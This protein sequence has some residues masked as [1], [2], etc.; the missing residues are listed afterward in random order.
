MKTCHFTQTLF[1]LWAKQS[2]LLLLNAA[3]LAEKHEIPILMYD[4]GRERTHNLPHSRRANNHYTS[5]AVCSTFAYHIWHIDV[6]QK[7]LDDPKWTWPLTSV[8]FSVFDMVLCPLTQVYHISHMGFSPWEMCQIIHEPSISF[9]LKVKFKV[10]LT[11][12]CVQPV[13]FLSF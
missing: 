2:L 12:L 10:F 4:Q 8:K 9:D 5:Q 1:W 6:P 7:D 13:T 11:W 3:C